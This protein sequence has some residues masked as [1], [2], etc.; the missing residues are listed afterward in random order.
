MY[1]TPEFNT[2]G[3]DLFRD[4]EQPQARLSVMGKNATLNEFN[5]AAVLDNLGI[6]YLFQVS[7]WGGRTVAGGQILDF[8]VW[9][10]LK[11]GLQVFG[12]YWHEGLMSNEDRYKITLLEEF[13]GQ[14]VIV[15]WGEETST[16]DDARQAIRNK[17]L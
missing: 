15:L 5:V 6:Q 10:P 13:L 4:I 8:L 1:S 12:N 9:T 3:Q 16:F 11:Q 2:G 14:P 7:F 17:V